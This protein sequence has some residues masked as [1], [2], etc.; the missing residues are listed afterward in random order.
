MRHAILIAAFFVQSL[1][2][3]CQQKL[4]GIVTDATDGKPVPY[5]SIGITRTPDGTVSGADGAFSITLT[6][7]ITGN[8]TLK[9]SSIGYQSKAFTVGELRNKFQRGPL[10]VLLD[11]SVNQLKQVNVISG[12]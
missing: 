4:T 8:D 9:F 1:H 2:A 6:E 11:K 7:G 5:A 10:T 3:F 12:R